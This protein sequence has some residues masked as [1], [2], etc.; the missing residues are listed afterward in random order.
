VSNPFFLEGQAGRIEVWTHAPAGEPR[1]ACLCFH[2]HPLY[3]GN[4]HN[5][6]LYEGRKA[7]V[8]RGALCYSMSFRGVGL[9]AGEYD[10]GEGEYHDAVLLHEHVRREHPAFPLWILGYS[11][12]AWVGLRLAAHKPVDRVFC[13]GLPTTVYD[14]S[15]LK[16]HDFPITVFQGQ[17]DEMGAPEEIRNFFGDWY[18]GLDLVTVPESDH[19]FTTTLPL[20]VR[21]LAGRLG[22][23]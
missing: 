21:A 2:P 11:F 6:V 10:L 9:T 17:R 20:L 1:A 16:G 4:V 13:I 14:F 7:L 8:E 15:F 19:F 23:G 18:P 22:S 3:G 12:G 5:K